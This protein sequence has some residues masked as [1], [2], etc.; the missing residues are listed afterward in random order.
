M[1]M[2]YMTMMIIMIMR[3]MTMMII[4]VLR[5]KP[6]M[7]THPIGLAKWSDMVK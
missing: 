5:I 7:L 4:K 1:I 6:R 2:R 3:Y